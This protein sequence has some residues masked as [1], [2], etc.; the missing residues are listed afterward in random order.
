MPCKQSIQGLARKLGILEKVIFAGFHSNPYPIMKHARLSM[1]TSDYEGLPT[2]LIESLALQVPV[3][4]TDCPSGPREILI[5]CFAKYIMPASDVNTIAQNIKKI[6]TTT[7]ISTQDTAALLD[8]FS[9][10]I[11]CA[12]YLS[13]T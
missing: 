12:N 8:R 2:V 1:L 13:L 6:M 10:E 5:G 11:A 9:P 4:S 7:G 3:L